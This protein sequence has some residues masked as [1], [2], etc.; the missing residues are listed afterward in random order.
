MTRPKAKERS[1]NIYQNRFMLVEYAVH[2]GLNSSKE[3][4]LWES[5]IK[6]KSLQ[7]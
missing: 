3:T 4:G 6:F 7:Y 1:R 5:P 2:V